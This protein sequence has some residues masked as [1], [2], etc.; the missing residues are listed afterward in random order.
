MEA[1]HDHL[2]ELSQADAQTYRNAIGVLE[3]RMSI[4]STEV[5]SRDAAIDVLSTENSALRRGL[6][7]VSVKVWR[8]ITESETQNDLIRTLEE[9][10][11]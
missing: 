2:V 5:D 3:Q 4:L 11:R 7:R 9:K 6:M 10:T 8:A 1:L